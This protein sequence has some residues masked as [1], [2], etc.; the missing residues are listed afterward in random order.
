VIPDITAIAE[1]FGVNPAFAPLVLAA[2]LTSLV[3]FAQSIARWFEDR[4]P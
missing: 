3:L 4:K 1:R 2:L